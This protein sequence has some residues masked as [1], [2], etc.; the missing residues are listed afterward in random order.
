MFSIALRLVALA[1]VRQG[2]AL[3]GR[4]GLG[5]RAGGSMLVHNA[6]GACRAGSDNAV[7]G[8]QMPAAVQ[9]GQPLTPDTAALATRPSPL[10]PKLPAPA[11]QMADSG[12]GRGAPPAPAAVPPAQRPSRP[13]APSPLSVVSLPAAA[14]A[15][16]GTPMPVTPNAELSRNLLSL[17]VRLV[18]LTPKQAGRTSAMAAAS[19]GLLVGV[20]GTGAARLFQWGRAEG[21]IRAP[22]GAQDAVPAGEDADM[23]PASDV[24]DTSLDEVRAQAVSRI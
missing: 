24:H 16:S 19:G 11:L 6:W 20:R 2:Q 14:E 22:E 12:S 23:A 21:N 9:S 13:R 5:F 1:Q 10:G 17:E 7:A 18:P 8:C 4:L 3:V 15:A